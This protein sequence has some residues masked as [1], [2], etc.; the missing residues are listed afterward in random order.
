MLIKK[1]NNQNV[2]EITDSNKFVEVVQSQSRPT[3]DDFTCIYD[4]N[5]GHNHRRKNCEYYSRNKEEI[6]RKRRMQYCDD[7]SKTCQRRY[8]QENQKRIL[9]SIVDK[10][11]EEYNESS[12]REDIR[13][14]PMMICISCDRL[15][16]IT[17]RL[18]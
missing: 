8:Y 4:S 16:L 10:H 6:C 9:R 14:G 15:F 11:A 2:L 18:C 7:V 13:K 12:Y 1:L 17:L 5:Y 3:I